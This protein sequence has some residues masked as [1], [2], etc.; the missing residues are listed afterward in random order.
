[1]P[2]CKVVEV[3]QDFFLSEYVDKKFTRD[4]NVILYLSIFNSFWV[5]WCL[6]QCIS[7][8]ISIFTTFL[9]A[10][11]TPL[12]QSRKTLH[13][14]KDNS[15]LAKPLAACTHLFSKFS[16]LFEPQVQKIAVFTYRSPHFCFPWRRPCDYHAMCCMDG[17]TIQCLPNPSQHI[18]IYL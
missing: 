1:M 17:K 5:I 10:L 18:P 12:W 14:W 3:L 7:P 6:S 15:V 4:Y 13:K 2:V 11:G 8:K 16:Q 9:F